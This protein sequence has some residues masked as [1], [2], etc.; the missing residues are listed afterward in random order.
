MSVENAKAFYRR[1]VSDETFRIQYQNATTEGDRQKLLFAEGYSF[2]TEEWE[3]AN[4]EISES[5]QGEISDAELE[6]VSGGLRILPMYGAPGLPGWPGS[7]TTW[8]GLDKKQ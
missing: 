4:A 2:T 1:M 3:T 7:A 6:A 5:S 8:P